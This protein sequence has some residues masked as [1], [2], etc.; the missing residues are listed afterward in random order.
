MLF[1]GQLESEA[2]HK[3]LAHDPST[4]RPDKPTAIIFGIAN[5]LHYRRTGE[6]PGGSFYDPQCPKG[7]ANRNSIL[8]K[9][10]G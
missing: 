2:P 7:K 6:L 9:V 3:P 1:W 10:G 8:K 4:A 5:S